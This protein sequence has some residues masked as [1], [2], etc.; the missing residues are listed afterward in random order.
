MF[1][2]MTTGIRVKILENNPKTHLHDK[3]L[4]NRMAPIL[5]LPPGTQSQHRKNDRSL[6]TPRSQSI[7]SVGRT[8][9]LQ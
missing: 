4:L 8:R 3:H 5:R 7:I 6:L 9:E 1:Q 2:E